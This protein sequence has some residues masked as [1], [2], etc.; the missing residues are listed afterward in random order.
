M[1]AVLCHQ[2]CEPEDLILEQL[3]PPQIGP[4]EALVDIH[5]TGINFP[6]CLMIAGKYQFQPAYPF[7]PGGEIAGQIAAVGDKLDG[8]KV[9]DMVMASTGSGGFSEQIAVNVNQLRPIPKGMDVVSAAGFS[10][11]YGTA[12]YALKNRGDLKAGETLLV[13]GAAGGVGIAAVELGKAMGAKVIAAASTDEKLKNAKNAGAD[14]L[15]N[16]SSG[17]LKDQVKALTSGQGA[18]VIYDPVGGELFDQCMRCI[19]WGGRV[20]VIGFASGQIPKVAMNLPLLKSCQIVGVFYGA[21]V[22]R[23]RSAYLENNKELDSL[24]QQGRLKPLVTQRFPL[25]E[26]ASALRCLMNRQAIGKVVL[27]MK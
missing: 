19:G 6:D 21:F 18:D 24:F 10:T 3:A 4:E 8:W 17:N 25:E 15:I 27:S 22:S 9:G 1:R 12:L 14:E 5:A 26:Y 11:T 20:L 13:L 16:Y 2:V 23:E 7:V